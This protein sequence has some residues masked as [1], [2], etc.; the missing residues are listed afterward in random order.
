MGNQIQAAVQQRWSELPVLQGTRANHREGELL[1]AF[2]R[3]HCF[4]ARN[5][6]LFL[7]RYMVLL[8]SQSPR[9]AQCDL[10]RFVI[11]YHYQP[12]RSQEYLE[13]KFKTN[14]KFHFLKYSNMNSTM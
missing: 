11:S 12:F 9:L 5:H 3:Q 10:F 14:L 7:F 8:W 1:L 6:L 2:V 13:S 4:L